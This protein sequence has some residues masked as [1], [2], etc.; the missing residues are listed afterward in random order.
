M[1][2]LYE[3]VTIWPGGE[4]VHISSSRLAQA[5]AKYNRCRTNEV[6][7]RIRKDGRILTIREADELCGGKWDIAFDVVRAA[8]KPSIEKQKKNNYH[9]KKV[10]E[11]N[12]K[13]EILRIFESMKDAAQD[14]EIGANTIRKW[15]R[16]GQIQSTGNR[17]A[18]C[19]VEENESNA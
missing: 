3:V 17:Y 9:R 10:A 18:I 7:A 16:C 8:K 13:G 4:Y 19:E 12:E 5:A 15:V 11:I 1:K 2:H 6:C 14:L